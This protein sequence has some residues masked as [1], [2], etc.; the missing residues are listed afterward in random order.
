MIHFSKFNNKI[1]FLSGGLLLVALSLFLTY[2]IFTPI[3]AVEGSIHY[4]EQIDLPEGSRLVIQLRSVGEQAQLGE[5]IAEQIILNPG[6]PPF[7]FKLD[8]DV[9]GLNEGSSYAVTAHLYDKAGN[10]LFI[11]GAPYHKITKDD[12]EAISL[13]LIKVPAGEEN[14]ES[15]IP[16]E[17]EQEKEN[18]QEVK[19]DTNPPIVPP[20]KVIPEPL[21]VATQQAA[22]TI[23]VNVYYDADYILPSGAE[24]VIQLSDHGTPTEPGSSIIAEGTVLNPGQPP[25]QVNLSYN[26]DDI[27]DDHIYLFSV[28]VYRSD[29]KLLLVNSTFGFER[30]GK[31]LEDEI[32][33]HLISVFPSELPSPQE[34]DGLVSGKITYNNKYDLPAGSELVIQIRD[35]SYQDAPSMVVNERVIANPGNSP[36]SF[37]VGY[38]SDDIS[39]RRL[40]AI[41]AAIYNAEKQLLLINDTVYEVITRGHPNW[42]RVPLV[43]TRYLLNSN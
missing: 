9:E 12:L 21:E 1:W 7:V 25:R 16:Q 5:L 35:V 33:V 42:V 37:E 8:Y 31:Q 32:D 18:N 40:Y 6:Q 2:Y 15:L 22:D 27:F 43:A 24:L 29:K 11:G 41:S 39:E 26:P 36:I 28:G 14:Q 20:T 38:N 10:E 13:D 3:P 30:P 19:T 23:A 4:G 34:L 17:Q